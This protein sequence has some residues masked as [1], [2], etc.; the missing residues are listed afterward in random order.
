VIGVGTRTSAVALADSAAAVLGVWL[1]IG[2]EVDNVVSGDEVALGIDG[3]D[4]VITKAGFGEADRRRLD[5]LEAIVGAD[6]RT[7]VTFGR[8]VIL[9][10][11]P[12]AGVTDRLVGVLSD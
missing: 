8:G 2:S 3:D 9:D 7:E 5:A 4:L 11:A 6:G 10:I 1:V 12:I